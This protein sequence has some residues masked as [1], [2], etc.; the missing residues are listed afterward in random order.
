MPATGNVHLHAIVNSYSAS[1]TWRTVL[2]TLLPLIAV[3]LAASHA[4]IALKWAVEHV[5]EKVLWRGSVEEGEV[6][7]MSV[8]G[9]TGGGEGQGAKAAGTGEKERQRQS[10]VGSGG[11]WNGAEEGA[12]EIARVGKVE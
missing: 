4:H 8:R 9:T 6:A 3:A 7:K 1:S 11:F 5:L 12:R 2:P 10:D